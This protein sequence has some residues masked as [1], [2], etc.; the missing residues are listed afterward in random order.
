[1]TRYGHGLVLKRQGDK[2]GAE[3]DFAAA[4]AI[5]A[6]IDKKVEDLGYK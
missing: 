2:A 6:G 3:Q 5:D 1:M 4:R